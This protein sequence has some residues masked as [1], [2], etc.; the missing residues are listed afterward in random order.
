MNKLRYDQEYHFYK[1]FEQ[2][3]PAAYDTFRNKRKYVNPVF[4][5]MTPEGFN[6]RLT[7]LQQCCRQGNTKTM[8]DRGGK[9]ANNRAFGRP[10]FCVLRL[11]DFYNQMI[12]IDSISLDY[13]VSDGLQWDMN[14]EGNGVQPMLC[15]VNI[16]FKFI[17]GGDIT[18][19]VRRLQNA[20]SFNYYANTSFYDNRADRV[21]YQETNWKTMGGAGNDQVDIDKSYAYISK[22]YGGDE[23][24]IVKMKTK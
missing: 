2:D 10:P 13:S 4:H 17:V 19:P 22:M 8:S 7:F 6:A 15:R 20:M 24:N 3:H 21:A 12:V 9:T 18:G 11:G 14:T 5:S 23:N 1:K 16:N